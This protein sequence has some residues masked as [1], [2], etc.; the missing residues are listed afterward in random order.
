MTNIDLR[1]KALEGIYNISATTNLGIY[2]TT[3]YTSTKDDPTAEWMDG[4]NAAVT[5]QNGYV[6]EIYAF[7]RKLAPKHLTIVEDL[8]LEGWIELG[9]DEDGVNL[10]VA[11][12]DTFFWACGDCE[13]ITVEELSDLQECYRQSPKHGGDLWV[14]RRRGMRPQ[15]ALYDWYPESEWALFDA[16]GPK[17]EVGFGNPEKHPNDRD[18]LFANLKL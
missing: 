18:N 11:C 12:N 4:W 7:L 13:I 17:R 14:A 10:A 6:I 16:C 5:N 3:G 1:R 2:P 8:L 9:N 15:G